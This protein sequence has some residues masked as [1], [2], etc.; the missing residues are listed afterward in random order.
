M[1]EVVERV[2]SRGVTI[3]LI[4]HVMRFLTRLSSRVMIMHHGEKIYEG[5]PEGL[6]SDAKVVDVYLGDGASSRLKAQFDAK[7]QP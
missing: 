3:V 5:P 7:A 1:I 4:E 6:A 2:R